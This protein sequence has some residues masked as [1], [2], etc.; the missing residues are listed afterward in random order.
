M[1]TRYTGREQPP[2]D[3][4]DHMP[5]NDH[6]Q[7]ILDEIERQLYEDDPKLAAMVA[8]AVGGGAERWRTRLAGVVFVLGAVVMFVSFPS[9]WA[10]AGA[11]F[12]FMVA[13]AGWLAFRAGPSR[14]GLSTSAALDEWMQRFQHRR[15]GDG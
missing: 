6:E 8:K 10:I 11:G 13:S 14:F 12:V 15:R 3:S 9:S 2:V 5:L 1:N 7:E 4:G